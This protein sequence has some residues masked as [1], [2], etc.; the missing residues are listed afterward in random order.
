MAT[1]KTGSKADGEKEEEPLNATGA[2]GDVV[3]AALTRSP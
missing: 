2:Y 3:V 1:K